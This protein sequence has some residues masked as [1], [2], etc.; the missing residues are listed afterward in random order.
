[1]KHKEIKIKAEFKQ[2]DLSALL[3]VLE[4]LDFEIAESSQNRLSIKKIEG[5]GFEENEIRFYQI[6]FSKKD[7]TIKYS[8]IS[9][10]EEDYRDLAIFKRLL[11]IIQK[12]ENLYS[13][14]YKQLLH[15]SLTKISKILRLD[16]DDEKY[17]QFNLLNELNELKQKYST[18]AKK[19]EETTRL[20]L[21]AKD[22]NTKLKK[23]IN[24]LKA[25]DDDIMKQDLIEWINAHSGYI[26]IYE[27]SKIHKTTPSRVKSLLKK[28]TEKGYLERVKE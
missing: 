10:I 13:F 19:N 1:M 15:L 20:L 12:T 14:N 8:V 24:R 4:D 18:I 6:I 16:S 3:K 28:M 25:M 22:E 26:D 2:K 11:L 23:E 5:T 21:M 9:D 17:K 7:I 27:Y